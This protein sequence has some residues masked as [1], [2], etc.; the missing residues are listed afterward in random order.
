MS[1]RKVLVIGGGVAGPALALFLQ[2]AGLEAAI[3]E[4][5]SVADSHAGAFLNVASNGTDVL[6]TLGLADA[7]MA[8]GIACPRMMMWNGDG[9]RL[10]EMA[11]GL[12]PGEGL[13]SVT[14]KRSTLHAILHAE[15]VR[16]G[17]AVNFD[18]RLQEIVVMDE[19]GQQR[20]CATFADGTRAEADLLIGC[21]GIHSRTRQIIDPAAPMPQYTGL[22]SCGGYARL[23]QGV[24]AEVARSTQ[25]LVFGKRAFFGYLVKPDGEIY[26]FEN[27]AH[28][29]TPRRSALEAIPDATWKARLLALHAD[30]QPL[31]QAIIRATEHQLGMYPIYDIPTQRVW[32]KG[33]IALIGDAAHATSPSAGQG[34]ALA[35]ED[36]IVLA[37]CLRDLPDAGAAFRSFEQMR[38]ARVERVV[39][40]SR[41]LGENKV[42]PNGLVRWMRDL[43]MPFFLRHFAKDETLAWL[44]GHRVAW[45]A[46]VG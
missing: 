34:A 30:D 10:G 27:L 11:N 23:P 32:H 38:R 39:K 12:R 2:R 7:V 17:I 37:K 3:Y 29:G 6:Q 33:S 13:P 4:A 14:I 18:K 19:G 45:D 46:P 20:V 16:Q 31:I 1:K 8:E 43:T 26:W 44:V 41:Q 15:V 24:P 25:H 21:D 28:P 36:A 35:L 40:S 5:G 9:K 42:A 22:I